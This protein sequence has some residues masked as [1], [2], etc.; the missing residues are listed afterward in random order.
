MRIANENLKIGIDQKNETERD[1]LNFL[2]VRNR[3]FENELMDGEV[4]VEKLTNEMELIIR[5][6]ESDSKQYS[7]KTRQYQ[8]QQT[9]QSNELN[10]IQSVLQAT[11]DE[12]RKANADR[13]TI[14]LEC[15][16]LREK[17]DLSNSES[18]LLKHRLTSFESNILAKDLLSQEL[19]Q[20]AATN[21]DLQLR[22]NELTNQLNTLPL[23]VTP[24]TMP[25]SLNKGTGEDQMRNHLLLTLP[26][27]SPVAINKHS[28]A[29]LLNV[30]GIVIAHALSP[31]GEPGALIGLPSPLPEE[32]VLVSNLTKLQR[33]LPISPRG[34]PNKIEH[35]SPFITRA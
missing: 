32:L 20:T 11:T 29:A 1:E 5:K 4:M 33:K 25:L 22:V 6:A 2:R 30:H 16:T 13:D 27:G 7:I 31:S 18:A 8:E 14:R 3:T 34:S 26:I 12:L 15:S 17:C 23:P 21:A 10:R 24:P 28:N 19:H 9:H 35:G